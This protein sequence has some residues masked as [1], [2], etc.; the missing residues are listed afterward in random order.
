MKTLTLVR[1]AKSSWNKPG[2][3]DRDRPLSRRGERD[4]PKMGRR[5]LDA[6]IRPSLIISSPAARAW[7]TATAI[8]KAIGY[9]REFMHRE[10]DLYLASLDDLLEIVNA[11]DTGFNNIM[12]VGHNPGLTEFAN[13]LS[14]N[15]TDNVPTTGV[16][17]VN[18]DQNDW[19]LY[20]RPATKLIIYDYPKKTP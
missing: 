6:G 2:L 16:V 10:D 9:P 1:H 5:I 11:Q 3:R 19:N 20:D 18:I 14:P 4:A 13:Y 17:S 12:L 8:A 15:L 7:A